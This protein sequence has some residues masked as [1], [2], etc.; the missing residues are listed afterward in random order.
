M[1]P[2]KHRDL[3]QVDLR[4]S[5]F[6]AYRADELAML[7]HLYFVTSAANMFEPSI[8]RKQRIITIAVCSAGYDVHTLPH[9]T[10]L[11]QQCTVI[12]HLRVAQNHH[13]TRLL[14]KPSWVP[15][16]HMQSTVSR[17]SHAPLLIAM[18]MLTYDLAQSLYTC[19]SFITFWYTCCSSITL[20]YT[21]CSS[22]TSM[23]AGGAAARAEL[24]LTDNYYDTSAG[25]R[26]RMLKTTEKLDKTGDRIQQGRAQLAETEVTSAAA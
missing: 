5:C 20:L 10:L 14:R 22:T 26:D 9:H 1:T 6:C 17:Q 13:E 7:L 23:Q 18:S 21:C 25:Q 2:S 3:L 19:C 16:M 11:C 4:S 15:H 24:G 12:L 8:K